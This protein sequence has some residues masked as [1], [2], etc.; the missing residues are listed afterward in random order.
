[1]K[2]QS[3]ALNGEQEI[4][5][6]NMLRTIKDFFGESEAK[7]LF[8]VA[9][10]PDGHESIRVVYE[11]K[12]GRDKLACHMKKLSKARASKFH[13]VISAFDNV[14]KN[15]IFQIE[16]KAQKIVPENDEGENQ[17]VDPAKEAVITKRAEYVE[18]FGKNPYPQI[19]NSVELMQAK[20]DETTLLN[21]KL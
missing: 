14:L 5:V 16:T 10:V 11:V 1:M 13:R 9:K 15:E 4:A 12:T 2:T 3:M 6:N 7:K 20:I 21:R 8:T 17:D 19:M 18:V